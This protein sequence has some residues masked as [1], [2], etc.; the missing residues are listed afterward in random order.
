MKY[1]LSFVILALFLSA[2]C[3]WIGQSSDQLAAAPQATPTPVPRPSE[4]IDSPLEHLLAEIAKP[5]DGKVGVG[6]LLLETGDAAYLDPKGHFAMQSVYKLPIAMALAQSIDRRTLDVDTDISITPADYVRRGFHSPIRNLNPRGTVMRLD[7]IVRYSLSESD[8]SASDVLLRLA[9]GPQNV[10]QYLSSI[11]ITDIAVTDSTKD[12]SRD[13]DT[14]YRNWATPEASVDLLRDLIDRQAGLSERTTTLI[15]D[16]MLEAET[17]RHRI[18]KGLPQ[19]ATLAHKTGTGGHPSE[20]P[21]YWKT[22]AANAN[23]SPANKNIAKNLSKRAKS[24]PSVGDD[25]EDAEPQAN[26]VIS[27]VNDIG[28]ITLPDGRHIILAVYINDSLSVNPDK[29]IADI[30]RA[31]CERWTT[32]QLLDEGQ[33]R[34]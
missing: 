7:D 17:G 30:S 23:T 8:G 6:A 18:H 20:V 11:G 1:Y 32:G 29:V 14:Q 5:A 22:V 21:G 28:I 16:S 9:G 3:T 26:E 33:F 12:V 10:Q 31:V 27:A 4:K 13:W 34:S 2:G 25:S 24:G 15:F 19:G